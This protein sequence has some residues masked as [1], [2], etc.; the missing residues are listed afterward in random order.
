M[1]LLFRVRGSC[2]RLTIELNLQYGRK[3]SEE[4][5]SY[6]SDWKGLKKLKGP[7]SGGAHL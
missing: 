7:G 1:P 3:Y 5:P 2:Y 4:G 6:F